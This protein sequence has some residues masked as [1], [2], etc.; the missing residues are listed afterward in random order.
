MAMDNE[1]ITTIEE[2]EMYQKAILDA[3]EWGKKI[4]EQNRRLY[5]KRIFGNSR[6]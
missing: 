4:D 2:F 1:Y 6:A 5:D 3:I